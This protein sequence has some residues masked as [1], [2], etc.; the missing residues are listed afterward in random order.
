M[1]VKQIAELSGVSIGTVDRVLHGRGRVSADTKAKVESIVKASGY[2]PN[3][4]A[5]HLKRNKTYRFSALVPRR[6]EDSFYWDLAAGGM[7]AAAEEIRSFN[8]TVDIREFDRYDPESFRSVSR[9][10]LA[11]SSDGILLA[12]VL[13]REAK[14]FVGRLKVPYVY[15]DASLPGNPPLVSIG[16]DAFQG[17]VLAARLVSLFSNGVGPW[18]LVVVHGEDHHISRRRDGFLSYAEGAGVRVLVVDEDNIENDG[19]ARSILD[20]ILLREPETKGVFVTNASSHRL[21]AACVTVRQTRSLAVVGYDL[22]PEN[23]AMLR[24]GGLDAI[25]SQ[26][27]DVQAG[28]GIMALYRSI[29]LGEAVEPRIDMPLDVFIREN[30]PPA[31][32]AKIRPPDEDVT[33]KE[34]T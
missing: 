14:E 21:A 17:G 4:I 1:T 12:P 22:V 8:V 32:G 20:G 7:E 15:F 29:V 30:L 13:P 16:Q 10:V 6:N 34:G 31:A 27:P 33:G 24:S 28:K 11:D 19:R 23:E 2:S 18:A 26:S 5:R 9:G 25:I 3:P